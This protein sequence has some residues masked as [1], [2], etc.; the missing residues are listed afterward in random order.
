MYKEL[1]II[2]IHCWSRLFCQHDKY[3]Q[4]LVDD[5]IKRMAKYVTKSDRIFIAEVSQ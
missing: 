4:A 5:C 3:D 1:C 2:T